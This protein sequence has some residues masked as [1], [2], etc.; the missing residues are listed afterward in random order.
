ML[1]PDPW[2]PRSVEWRLQAKA[3]DASTA[4]APDTWRWSLEARESNLGQELVAGSAWWLD[5]GAWAALQVAGSSRDDA[6]GDLGTSRRRGGWTGRVTQGLVGWRGAALGLTFG[7]GWLSRE[8]DRISELA[9]GR[10]M[11]P[12]DLLRWSLH[13]RDGSLEVETQAARLVSYDVEGGFRRWLAQHRLTWRPGGALEWLSVG[14]LLVYT[15]QA[16]DL[17]PATLAPFT[18]YFLRTFEGGSDGG[19]G[20]AA[21]DSTWL[22]DS[23]NNML[24]ADWS[25]RLA[26][27]EPWTLRLDGELIVDEFQIDAGDR[28]RLDDVMGLVLGL[29]T[30]RVGTAGDRVEAR[31]EHCAASRWL[32]IHP[33]RET[34]WVDRGRWIGNEE[35]GDIREWDLRLRWVAPEGDGP[36]TRP[37]PWRRGGWFEAA[38]ALK[39]KGET[40]MYQPWDA[41]NTAGAA[42]PSGVPE[43]SL[44]LR[45]DGRLGRLAGRGGLGLTLDGG[46]AWTARRQADH[47]AGRRREDAELRLRVSLDLAGTV[48][49][50]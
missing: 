38:L 25:L 40:A 44:V 50:P 23:E 33:G 16:R 2:S 43:H 29:E 19:G 37:A 28:R 15:G 30:L 24:L 13:T 47:V 17:D 8:S 14:D 45:L 49:H 10:H 39:E 11:P 27:R 42:V 7:R 32:Y 26:H 20:P 22:A 6:P 34:D 4:P 3:D 35:G 46:V 1:R 5:G 21:G 9:I 12:V 36:S 31:L 48:S 41:R 18:P